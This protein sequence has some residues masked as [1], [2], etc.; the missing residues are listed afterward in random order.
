MHTIHSFTQVENEVPFDDITE[1]NEKF[2]AEKKYLQ[3]TKVYYRSRQETGD[4]NLHEQVRSS[5]RRYCEFYYPEPH[6]SRFKI[7]EARK[8]FINALERGFLYFESKGMR[9]IWRVNSDKVVATLRMLRYDPTTP[10]E[11]MTRVQ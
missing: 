6:C 4:S 7:W 11:M 2:Q 3:I 9:A 1:V 8:A 10:K 5:E